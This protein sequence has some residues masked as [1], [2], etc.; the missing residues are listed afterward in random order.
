M[1]KAAPA[2]SPAKKAGDLN[3][4]IENLLPCFSPFYWKKMIVPREILFPVSSPP[5]RT[6]F[7]AQS[8]QR[9]RP[10]AAFDFLPYPP[11]INGIAE[12]KGERGFERS[13]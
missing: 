12:R 2:E 6:A 4:F 11:H 10:T 9:R 3:L 5:D 8:D 13:F 1:I 7:R